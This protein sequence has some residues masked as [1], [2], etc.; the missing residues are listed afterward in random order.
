[1]HRIHA[2]PITL[3]DFSTD[4]LNAPARHAL[5]AYV[6]VLEQLRLQYVEQADRQAWYSLIQ[7]LPSSYEQMRTCTM[8]YETL[9]NIYYAR[10]AHKLEEWHSFCR[11]IESLPYAKELIVAAE[12]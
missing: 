4:Q 12:E 3:T 10:K 2:R 8:N 5:S 7:L 6:Q 11:W 9:I 1:M